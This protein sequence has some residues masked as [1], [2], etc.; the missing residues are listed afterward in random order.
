MTQQNSSEPLGGNNKNIFP[1]HI[2]FISVW[3]T[4]SMKLQKNKNKIIIMMM[5]IIFNNNNK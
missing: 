4:N 3:C 1:S 2:S 5:M